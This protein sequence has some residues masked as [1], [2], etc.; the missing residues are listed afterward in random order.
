MS[1]NVRVVKLNQ[2]AERTHITMAMNE[3][4]HFGVPTNVQG[5]T[6]TYLEEA[7]VYLT[8]PESNPYRIEF[9]RFEPDSPM[10]EVVKTKPHAAFVV[11]SIEDSLQGQN[12]VIPPFD[13]TDTLRVAFLMDG[14]A[15]IE[16]MEKK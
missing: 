4:H 14:D 6:E 12:V 11:D 10:P 13:A 1:E 15:L 3:F 8:D 2:H 16:V 5:S 9:L 7:K